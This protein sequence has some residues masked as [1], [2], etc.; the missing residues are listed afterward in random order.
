MSDQPMQPVKPF[1]VMA[2]PVGGRC[3]LDCTYCYYT[4]KP[5]ELYPEVSASDMMMSDATLEAFVAQYMDAQP[6]QCEFGW[7]GGEPMV[8]GLDF[9]RKVVA[10]Q[11]QYRREGQAVTNAFQTNGTLLTE[12]WCEFL[13]EHK[14][15]VGI[16]LD[17]PP[18]WHDSFRKDRA[19]EGTFHKAWAGLQRL[20]KHRVEY[21]VLVTLNRI[22]APHAGDIYRYFVNRGVQYLQFIPILERDADGNVS[23]FSCTG[24]QFGKFSLE[25]F[26]QWASRDIGRVSERFIDNVM[27]SLIFGRPSMCC[28]EKRCAN[29]HVLEFNGDLYVCDHFV[30]APWKVGNIHD[31]P[32]AELVTDPKLEEFATLKTELPTVCRECEY[33][34]LC[35]GGCPKHHMPIGTAPARVN[36]FCEGY[37]MFFRE[38]LPSL[39][40]IAARLSAPQ[41]SAA[42]QPG[43]KNAGPHRAGRPAQGSAPSGHAKPK[44]ND[45]CPCGSGRKY[46]SCCAR[47]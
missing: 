18:Q 31:R 33:V 2:K 25:V 36:H 20:E 17:G 22:N 40:Q 15:L 38:A 3:N 24:E 45:P 13:A 43:P 1:H 42:P 28:Y 47:R 32:L 9:F 34:A 19:G 35:N 6:V 44:R 11:E 16:S 23:D 4:D 7:Q 27:H 46:K 12:E 39:R 41:R 30:Y 10:L 26:Q 21:N 8:A 5:G 37:K 29:A 14:M